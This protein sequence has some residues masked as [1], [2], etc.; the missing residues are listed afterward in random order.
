M[1]DVLIL[2][3]HPAF[4][5]YAVDILALWQ[6]VFPSFLP[7]VRRAPSF[8]GTWACR[9]M[10][11]EARA[12]NADRLVIVSAHCVPLRAA[13]IAAALP[14][15]GVATLFCESPWGLLCGE[16]PKLEHALP[17]NV[18]LFPAMS[19]VAQECG[20]TMAPTVLRGCQVRTGVSL[21]SQPGFS[22]RADY[23]VLHPDGEG[24]IAD[25]KEDK[26]LPIF[27]DELSK[28]RKTLPV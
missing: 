20:L 16:V 8:P 23:A 14:A 10:F 7:I 4:D 2:N 21:E 17:V 19:V 1:S 11:D 13:R 5:A 25:L 9:A 12:V 28:L 15:A 27:L 24:S 3:V 26:W 18:A 6:E 22:R